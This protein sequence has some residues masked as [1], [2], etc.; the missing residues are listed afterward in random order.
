MDALGGEGGDGGDSGDNG[1]GVWC[2][3]DNGDC[4]EGVL[5][6][7]DGVCG[8]GDGGVSLPVSCNCMRA[9]DRGL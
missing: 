3:G 7:G 6:E 5:G 8:A 4:G 1:D 2:E 9:R